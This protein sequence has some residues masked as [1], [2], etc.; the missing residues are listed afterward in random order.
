MTES[1]ADPS[2]RPPHRPARLVVITGTG[3][4]VGKTWLTCQLLRGLRTHDVRVAAR[5]PAQSFAPGDGPTDADLLA[6]ASGEEPHAVCPP[7]RSYE[8]PMAPPMAADALGR[9]P[10]SAADLLAELVW[11]PDLDAGFVETAGGVR[12]P[13]TDDTDSVGFARL[14]AADTTVLVADAGLGTINSIRL[15]STRSHTRRR[16]PRSST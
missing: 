3:T 13:L 10:F 4:G 16:L 7:N 6:A 5:K 11:Q 1:P 9:E 12:S 14:L 8:V 2:A 15:R